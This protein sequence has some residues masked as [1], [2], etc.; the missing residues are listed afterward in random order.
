[1]VGIA[2]KDLRPHLQEFP[3]V[4]RLDACLR[5]YRHED[6][7]FNSSSRRAQQSE[8]CLGSGICFEQF[9]HAV[10]LPLSN[11]QQKRVCTW[12]NRPHNFSLF[13]NHP[14]KRDV[15]PIAK[16]PRLAQTRSVPGVNQAAP[17]AA[18]QLSLMD[19][20]HQQAA[21]A[22]LGQAALTGVDLTMLLDQAAVFVAQTLS[23][24][25]TSFYHLTEDG[26][27][28]HMVA[29]FGWNGGIV[30]TTQIP[31]EP[32][33][34][35]AYVLESSEPVIIRDVRTI[36]AFAVPEFVREHGVISGISMVIP[37][38][39]RPWGV[40]EVHC[41]RGRT[42]V[43]DDFH[44][45]QSI[46]NVISTAHARKQSES[47][48]E[49]LA[50]F[51]EHN[52]N[53]V[54][55]L[56]A[57]ATVLYC[58]NA[59]RAAMSTLQRNDPRELLPEHTAEIVRHCLEKQTRV[60]NEEAAFSGRTLSWSFFPVASIGRV[61]GYAEDITERTSLEAQLR[62]SQKMEAI[63]QLAAGVAHDFNNILTI[64]QGL[65]RRLG[66]SASAE[67]NPMLEQLFQTTERA[68]SLTKQLLAFSRKQVMQPR[69][70]LLGEIVT[71]MS[72]MLERLIGE[73]ISL[74][75]ENSDNL[76]PVE[77]DASM[78]EQI[79]L[80]LAVNAK[81]A[82]PHG[83]KLIISTD[84]A[85]V[86]TATGVQKWVRLRVR[87]TGTGIAPEVM[88]RIFEPF[89]TTKEVGKGTGLGLATVFG[90]VKQHAGSVEVASE[91]N[92]G[93]TFTVLFP[94]SDKAIEQKPM[95]GAQTALAR[96][97]GETILLVEDEPLLRE[98]AHAIL[99]D[100]GY[101]VLQAEQGIDALQQWD[102]HHDRIT[103]LL[104]DM[105]LPGGMTGRELAGRLQKKKPGL[106]VIYSTGYSA[107]LLEA[108]EEPVHFLQKPYPPDT[109]MRAVRTCLDAA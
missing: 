109:L 52:P 80:N 42:F 75:V 50:A 58:N 73:T 79:V 46:A 54:I 39:P 16:H 91:L 23:I 61:H 105:V 101:Q 49:H 33:S 53:P 107:D 1:M 31:T 5:A 34:M 13:A 103:M 51:V 17:L 68:A 27:S 35:A 62:Q 64:M 67:Q 2:K 89:F 11:E 69:V 15:F 21:V 22:A 7:R 28:M 88:A 97:A 41:R 93:T 44:F 108:K 30:E 20:A 59:T 65:V 92:M 98:L 37:G 63:G 9:K 72:R 82:M 95:I 4:K 36:T 78:I 14:L 48:L 86:E 87:D 55:E 66:M 90:I 70:L 10:R 56:D 83:G 96:G 38:T 6:R 104:T 94:P 45:L 32:G 84:V 57:A 85:Q 12:S 29:G 102:Q 25:F 8:T 60:L 106:K 24:D 74:V 81:D 99:T 18:F 100:G 19:R 71:N 3:R 76:A 47:D 40:L 77:G 26:R 43:E